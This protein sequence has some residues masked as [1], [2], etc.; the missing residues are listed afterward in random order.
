MAIRAASKKQVRVHALAAGESPLPARPE[1]AHAV[2]RDNDPL[3]LNVLLKA[4]GDGN[5]WAFETL[6]R[7]TSARLFGICLHYLGNRAEAEEVLQE[8]YI[9]LWLKASSFDPD[10]AN[11][12]TWLASIARNKAIDRRRARRV[13]EP[14]EASLELPASD[15]VVESVERERQ[16]QAIERCLATL[17]QDH[18][19][20][21]R[22]AFFEGC[23]YAELAERHNIA[24]GTMKSWIRRG[25]QRLGRCLGL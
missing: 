15:A 14:L 12:G 2:Q 22:F 21:I 23:S 1:T 24:L 5:R 10:L 16:H 13:H 8:V 4:C 17:E 6:Y 9:S 20:Y 7:A 11:A 25:L 3:A 19:R 18:Q